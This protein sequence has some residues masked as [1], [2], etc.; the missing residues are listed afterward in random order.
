LLYY[1]CVREFRRHQRWFADRIGTVC[2]RAVFAQAAFTLIEML[3]SMV[4]MIIMF[5]MLWGF[6][7]P[8]HQREQKK[9]CQQNLQRLYLALEIYANDNHG[10][11]PF[12][13]SA[14]NSA[15]ALDVLVPKYTVDT[16]SFICPGSKDS[17]LPAGESIRKRKISYAYYMGRRSKDK[18][19]VLMSDKQID[20]ASKIAEQQVF[21]SNGKAP[22]NN[23]H[24]YGGNFL[25]T[26]GH[27]QSSSNRAPFSLVMPKHVVLLNP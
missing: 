15:E 18:D 8:S 10:D 19:E 23:H 12:T 7:S 26:D 22:G 13:P 3:I 5:T 14:L 4:L 21:S 27:L 17:E 11:F 2:R 24:Q 20:T 9:R 6:G 16:G 25:F 1:G